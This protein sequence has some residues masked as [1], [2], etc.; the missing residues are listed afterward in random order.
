MIPLKEV[1]NKTLHDSYEKLK[2]INSCE[3]LAIAG[4]ENI[5]IQTY[6]I[7]RFK[8]LIYTNYYQSSNPST[9]LTTADW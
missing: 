3:V 7:T 1:K 5:Y 6:L 8:F 2:K 9:R 4:C